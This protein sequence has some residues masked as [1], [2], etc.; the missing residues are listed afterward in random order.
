MI[1]TLNAV[2]DLEAV[3]DVLKTGIVIPLYKGSGRDPLQ[4]EG[5]TLSSVMSRSWSYCS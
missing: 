3:P 2:F 5:V 1:G 4:V